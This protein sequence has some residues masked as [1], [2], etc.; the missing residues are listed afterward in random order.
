MET[1]KKQGRITTIKVALLLLFT[2]M[3]CLSAKM[4][5]AGFPAD[6]E[7]QLVMSY[8]LATGDRLFTEVWDTIQTSGFL[9][10]ALIRVYLSLT[11]TSTGIVV[12]LR[13]CGLVLQALT[14]LLLYHT[15]K[16]H[17][18][19]WYACL[20]A[21]AYY[22]VFTKLIAMP[23]FSN[24][25]SWFLTGMLCLMFQVAECDIQGRRNKR[26][27]LLIGAALCYCLAVLSTACVTLVPVIAVFLCLLFHKSRRDMLACNAVFFGVCLVTG[28]GYLGFVVYENG[29]LASVLT[30]MAN[31]LSGDSTHMSGVNIVGSSKCMT[32][33]KELWKLLCY[34]AV[35][36]AAAFAFTG[37]VHRKKKL[38]DRKF[39]FYS[40]WLYLAMLVT[41]IQWFPMQTGYEGLR[42]FI[43]VA[44]ICGALSL[45]GGAKDEPGRMRQVMALF[46]ILIF[47]GAYVHVLCISNVPLIQNLS[48]LYGACLWGLISLVFT[49][50]AG[51]R[52][53]SL[54][55]LLVTLGFVVIAGSGYTLSSGAFGSHIF[56]LDGIVRNGPAQN[57]LMSKDAAWVYHTDYETFESVVPKRSNVL[58]ITD[59]F[60]N[61]SVTSCYLLNDVHISHY[62]VNSTPTFSEK[63]EE[64]WQQF[65]EKTPDVVMVNTHAVTLKEGDWAAG[66][67]SRE[68]GEARC[69][70]TENADYYFR[71]KP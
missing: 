57:C 22:C 13:A 28:L 8:R 12:F 6:E 21:I 65:P 34:L 62:S 63:L 51:D 49:Y 3:V 40:C 64:Y 5:F 54:T 32:Y 9:C 46:G 2:G 16:R 14:A 44:A 18:A 47:A 52:R 19:K 43:P 53:A 71:E 61:T 23:D 48:F 59:F 31:T 45:R 69:L 39:F 70:H 42:L 20:I 66:Y 27:L 38:A 11:G 25:Q 55:G 35:S 33:L 37:W 30:N 4:L 17:T 41:L 29:S 56:E 26:I 58:I 67:L 7:Y 10:A 36:A 68:F 50:G 1:G 15:L 24:M 60:R